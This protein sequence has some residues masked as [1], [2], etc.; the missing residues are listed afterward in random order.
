MIT[1]L[2]IP[3]APESRSLS[4][5]PKAARAALAQTVQAGQQ[6]SLPQ[7]SDLLSEANRV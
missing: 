1:A 2:P 7:C 6:L 4:P 5:K 3:A